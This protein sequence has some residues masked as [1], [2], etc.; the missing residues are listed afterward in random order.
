VLGRAPAT[1]AEL[2]ATA[3]RQALSRNSSR[4]RLWRNATALTVSARWHPRRRWSRRTR[5]FFRR[6]IAC[7]TLAPPASS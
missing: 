3:W 6:A 4:W 5:Q 1:F 2:A 7:S